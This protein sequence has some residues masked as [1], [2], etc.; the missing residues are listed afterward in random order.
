MHKKVS[1]LILL[2][3]PILPIASCSTYKLNQEYQVEA[4]VYREIIAQFG[5]QLTEMMKRYDENKD[6]TISREE[7]RK[8]LEDVDKALKLFYIFNKKK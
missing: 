7:S 3:L 4:G 8:F 6:G 1:K 5:P 2:V